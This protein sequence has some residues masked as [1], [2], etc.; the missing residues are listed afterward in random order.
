MDRDSQRHCG[1]HVRAMPPPIVGAKRTVVV[2][3]EEERSRPVGRRSTPER[4]LLKGAVDSLGHTE[5]VLIAYGL[6]QE[7]RRHT[8]IGHGT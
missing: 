2:S 7:V 3:R 4:L 8:L 1:C 6:W 5:W